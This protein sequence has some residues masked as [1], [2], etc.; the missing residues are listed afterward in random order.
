MSRQACHLTPPRTG[1][2]QQRT[3]EKAYQD[4]RR[5]VQEAQPLVDT[6]A[7]LTL[8]HL[9]LKLKKLKLEEG[10]LSV[11]DRDNRLLLEK[12]SCIMRTRGQASS[13]SAC[14]RRSLDR[15]KRDQ[16]HHRVQREDKIILERITD[17][18]PSCPTQRRLGSR[19][20]AETPREEEL[21]LKFSKTTSW[22]QKVKLWVGLRTQSGKRRQREK[23]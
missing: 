7:P 1:E 21:K 14:T 8:G 2:R 23:W 18:E 20:P 6:R 13:R 3:W 17:S 16:K 12:V 11:I 4:H 19:E 10:R 22:T 15:G 5:K 9:H